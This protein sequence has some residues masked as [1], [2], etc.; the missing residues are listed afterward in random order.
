MRAVCP[1][2]MC[3]HHT[4]DAAV[5]IHLRL[6]CQHA[7]HA[8]R[9]ASRQRA[10]VRGGGSY[11]LDHLSTRSQVAE[12]LPVNQNARGKELTRNTRV[13]T[14]YDYHVLMQSEGCVLPVFHG[15]WKKQPI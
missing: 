13:T 11:G 2:P 12:V 5:N 4:P 10:P 7:Q 15:F 8:G 9:E 14:Y 1:W 6:L 3:R